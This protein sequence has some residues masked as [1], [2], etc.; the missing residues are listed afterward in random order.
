MTILCKAL[1]VGMLFSFYTLGGYRSH[2]IIAQNRCHVK[3][4][5][6]IWAILRWIF[7]LLCGK[8]V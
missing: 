1:Q 7:E 5:F 4:E 2:D 8:I 6:E 3:S